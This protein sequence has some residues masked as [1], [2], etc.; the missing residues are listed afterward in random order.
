MDGHEFS[1]PFT[2]LLGA[3]AT[4]EVV[5]A[6]EGGATGDAMWREL[7][8]SGFLDALV[9]EEH[10]GAGLSLA[11]VEPLIEAVGARAVPMP[12]AE[13]MVAR[14]LLARAGVVAPEGPI[15][16]VTSTAAG[17]VVSA[18]LVATHVLLDTGDA[19]LM[20]AR[21]A[22]SIE[23]TGVVHSLAARISWAGAIKGTSIA[24]PAG[25]LRPIAA[26][27]RAALMAGA[28]E[29]LLEM[30]AAFANERVQFGKPIGR[31]QALQQNLA[32]MAQDAVATRIAAQ[33]ACAHGLD[34][35]LMAAAT[36]KSVASAAAARIAATAHAVHGAI[37]ISEE[38]DLQLLTRRLHEWRVADGSEGYWNGVLGAARLRDPATTVDW[39]RARTFAQV[40]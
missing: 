19:L 38:H 29:R 22:L 12:V 3:I 24:R 36:A 7:A 17:Q 37:G 39:L 35:P 8:K 18:A 25:G 40:D 9:A 27:I 32:V 31:Q 6:V 15:A 30:T 16:L 20:A 26:V 1:E 2:R 21:G 28:G 13:T 4:P 34:V 11:A 33:L 5:R 10:G 14:A 23:G